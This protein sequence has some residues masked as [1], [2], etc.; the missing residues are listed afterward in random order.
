MM[1]GQQRDKDPASQQDIKK[2]RQKQ[3]QQRK[4]DRKERDDSKERPKPAEANSKK[5]GSH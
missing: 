1:I 4:K 2:R 5:F 3:E